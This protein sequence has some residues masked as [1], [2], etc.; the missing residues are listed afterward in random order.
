MRATKF[1][2]TEE[3]PPIQVHMLQH[4]AASRA[5]SHIEVFHYL[6]NNPCKQ[7]VSTTSPLLISDI[8]YTGRPTIQSNRLEKEKYYVTSILCGEENSKVATSS[9]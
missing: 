8:A 1:C 4:R 2:L 3:V 7:T 6:L 9:L 5:Y